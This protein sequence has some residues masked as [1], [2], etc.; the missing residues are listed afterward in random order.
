MRLNN[1]IDGVWIEATGTVVHDLNP[2]NPEE[3]IATF[4][5]SSAEEVSNAVAA[6]HQAYASW[7]ATPAPARGRIL[8]RFQKLLIEHQQDYVTLM[9]AEQGKTWDEAQ[10]EFQKGA[11]LVEYFAGEGFRLNG[12]TIPSEVPDNFTYTVRSPLGVA[13]VIT[14]WNFPFAIPLWKMCPALVAGNTVVFKPASFTPWIAVRIVEDLVAA[15]VPHGVVNLILGSGSVAGEA[16]V[17]DERIRAISFTGSNSVGNRLAALLA[18]RPVK[19]T[20]EMGGKNAAVVAPSAD[21]AL[22]VGGVL[23][24]AFGAAGQRCTATSRVFVQAGVIDA[25][26]SLLVE[27]VRELAVGVPTNPSVNIGPLIS[28]EQLTR[29]LQYVED[30][31]HLGATV[32]F[33]GQRA[34]GPGYFMEPTVLDDVVLSMPVAHEEVFGPVLCL[35][36]Y[37]SLDHA[38]ADVNAVPYGLSAAIYTRDLVEAQRFIQ[39]VD[40]GMVH[41]N[42]PTI[43]GEAQLP[44]G[45]VKGSGL[46]PREMGHEGTLFFTETKTVFVDYSSATRLGNFY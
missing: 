43:G 21:L 5:N 29:S 33:G 46:G 1:Y 30:A 36:P 34:G 13:G 44:F 42:N 22:A 27:R 24:G 23:K 10:G 25:F 7:A 19:V 15:G 39:G 37:E 31:V 4:R 3:V 11:N 40:V 26:R 16:L 32:R 17:K 18:G 38:I 41:V 9:M 12:E 14:P 20:M 2:S 45:G 35:L 28:E 8:A 6:A